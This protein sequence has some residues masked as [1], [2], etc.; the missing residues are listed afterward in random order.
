MSTNSTTPPPEI[1]PND[2]LA[3]YSRALHEY[4]LRLWAE[5]RRA[6][7]QQTSRAQPPTTTSGGHHHQQPQGESKSSSSTNTQGEP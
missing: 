7:E 6:A 4:T 1:D 3:L 2:P 5:S